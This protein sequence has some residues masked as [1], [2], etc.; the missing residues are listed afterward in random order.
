MKKVLFRCWFP[1]LDY[2]THK[3][4]IATR[5]YL[6]GKVSPHDQLVVL[7]ADGNAVPI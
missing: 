1:H 2:D 7:G 3:G 6:R 4:K 5:P